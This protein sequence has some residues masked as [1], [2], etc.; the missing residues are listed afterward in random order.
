MRLAGGSDRVR[1]LVGGFYS[2][3]KR[4]YGQSLLVV[5][6]DSLAAE[7]GFAAIG[8]SEGTYAARDELYYSDLHYDLK[9]G[10]VFGEA[11]LAASDRLSLTAGL[12]YYSFNETGL[13]GTTP[14]TRFVTPVSSTRG[15]ASQNER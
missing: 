5:G 9:Q 10:A 14:P 15:T 6:S 4:D 1:W 12:R 13:L 3:N 7:E 8:W 11:T 2:S